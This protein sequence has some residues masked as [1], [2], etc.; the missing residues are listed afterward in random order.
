MGIQVAFY[1]AT[2]DVENLE[3]LLIFEKMEGTPILASDV[4]GNH[5]WSSK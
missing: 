5:S 1:G 4:Q 2:V 3:M